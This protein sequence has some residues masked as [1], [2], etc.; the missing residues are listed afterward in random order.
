MIDS[1][2]DVL[3]LM[4]LMYAI[5]ISVLYFN[6]LKQRDDYMKNKD[7]SLKQKEEDLVKRESI[8]VDKE[9]C[10]RELTKIKTLHTS[11]LD[12]LKSY[13]LPVKVEPFDNI[14]NNSPQLEVTQTPQ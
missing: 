2:S 5:V 12:I 14:S 6:D 4:L 13:S 1:I 8:I 7:Q 11:V 3:I 10:F 9:I